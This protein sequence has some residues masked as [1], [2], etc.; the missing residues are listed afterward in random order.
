MSRSV[1][2]LTTKY[3]RDTVLTTCISMD[4]REAGRQLSRRPLVAALVR[5]ERFSTLRGHSDVVSRDS[6]PLRRVAAWRERAHR[7]LEA[8]ARGRTGVIVEDSAW[9]SVVSRQESIGEIKTHLRQAGR[10]RDT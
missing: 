4:G 8:Q 5:H 9:E 6:D 1:S 2:C 7:R 10:A 3:S